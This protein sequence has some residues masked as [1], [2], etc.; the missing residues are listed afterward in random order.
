MNRDVAQLPEVATSLT[1]RVFDVTLASLGLV[2]LSPVL[3]VTAL[4]V[5]YRI[6]SPVLFRQTR[7]G[8]RGQ[9]FQIL[10]FRTMTN[11]VDAEGQLLPDEERLT[12]FGQLLRSTS[13]DELPELIN[14]VRGDMSLVGPRPLIMR[15]LERYTPEQARRNLARPGI[16]GLAQVRGRN[17]LSW[18]DRFALDVE[19]IDTWSLG[20][21]VRILFETVVTVLRR[22]GISTEGHATAPEFMGERSSEEA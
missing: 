8:L 12:R 1:K 21:D 5:R 22:D 7:P 4:L 2:V 17:A 13:L 9:P 15:Y 6:G 11:A 10:K 16:T 19:Y 3:L 20:L 18:E 14:V